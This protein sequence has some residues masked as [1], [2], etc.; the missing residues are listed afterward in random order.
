MSRHADAR[1]G[2]KPWT[3]G[4]SPEPVAP[5]WSYLGPFASNEERLTQ[6][7]LQA[8]TMPGP[9][10]A[11]LVRVPLPQVEILPDRFGFGDRTSPTIYDVV[12]VNRRYTNPRTSWFSGGPG[13]YSGTS[14]NTLGSV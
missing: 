3:P 14:R 4:V 5:R 12:E 13:S 2:Q 7:A 11:D 1:Y 10:I 8:N 9:E 6:Q